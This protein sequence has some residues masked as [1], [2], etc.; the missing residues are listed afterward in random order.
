MQ[1]LGQYKVGVTFNPSQN[2]TVDEIKQKAADLIDLINGI[3]LPDAPSPTDE[4]DADFFEAPSR[5]VEVL[6]LKRRAL[7]AIEDGAML[8]VNAATKPERV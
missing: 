8:A 4:S 6:S 1:T 5:W 7:E 3:P 2:P